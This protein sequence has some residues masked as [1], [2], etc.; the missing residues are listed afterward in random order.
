MIS[1]RIQGL[2]PNVGTIR[3]RPGASGVG[4]TIIS[5]ANIVAFWRTF[6]INFVVIVDQNAQR[7]AIQ[8]FKLPAF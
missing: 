5:I 1:T 6:I 4:A 8:V 3:L 7:S 2:G